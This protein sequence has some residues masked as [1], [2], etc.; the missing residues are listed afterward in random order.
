MVEAGG[1][2]CQNKSLCLQIIKYIKFPKCC[3]DSKTEI[4]LLLY[5][6]A[7]RLTIHQTNPIILCMCF[8]KGQQRA[9]FVLLC[10]ILQA[11]FFF[12]FD[13]WKNETLVLTTEHHVARELGTSSC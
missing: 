6:Y 2:C 7:Q 4:T 9:A 5:C 1:E 10:K 8:Y 12:C 13:L 3:S 11:L